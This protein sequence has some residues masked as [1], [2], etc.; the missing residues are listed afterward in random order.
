MLTWR[1]DRRPGTGLHCCEQGCICRAAD[2]A[3]C[4]TL[5]H[6]T[7]QTSLS[8]PKDLLHLERE[9]RREQ[10]EKSNYWHKIVL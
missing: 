9:L 4:L 6:A 10:A 5:A 2:S 7:A 8:D 3:I 1:Q